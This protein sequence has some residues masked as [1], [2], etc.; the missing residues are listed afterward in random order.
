MNYSVARIETRT[1]ASVGKFER[2][3]ERKNESYANLNVD[4]SQSHRNVHFKTTGGL[5][6]NEYLDKLIVEGKVSLRGLKK[7][8]KV[9]DELVLDVNSAYFEQHGVIAKPPGAKRVFKIDSAQTPGDF[10]NW[11]LLSDRFPLSGLK[12]LQILGLVLQFPLLQIALSK[13]AFTT[14]S[15]KVIFRCFASM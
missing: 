15:L 2:H 12:A 13:I 3:N 8:A 7:D 1:R 9:F 5:S 10:I 6:Y 14:K 11:H 4:C